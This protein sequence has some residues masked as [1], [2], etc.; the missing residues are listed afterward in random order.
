LVHDQLAMICRKL[1]ALLQDLSVVE[2]SLSKQDAADLRKA[3]EQ[4]KNLIIVADS[5][6]TSAEAQAGNISL[7]NIA[8]VLANRDEM[9]FA[10]GRGGELEKLS[11]V[12]GLLAN[13]PSSGSSERG[14]FTSLLG[15]LGG[16]AGYQVADWP[17]LAI[18]L[19]TPM[20]AG[21]AYNNPATRAYLLN[22]AAAPLERAIP[23]F[24]RYGTT[25]GLLSTET[26]QR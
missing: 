11:R 8:N 13:P 18:G 26:P 22:Q 17:G 12:S 20:A 1:E 16:A 23:A 14:Y 15:A 6:G 7:K 3:R 9:G 5:L 4:Y 10:R 21:M 2:R 19:A 25:A 24:T